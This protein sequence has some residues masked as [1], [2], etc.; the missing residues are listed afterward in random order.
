MCAVGFGLYAHVKTPENSLLV[1]ELLSHTVCKGSARGKR[2]LLLEILL[3]QI[4]CLL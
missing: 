4:D 2:K 1:Q 3:V